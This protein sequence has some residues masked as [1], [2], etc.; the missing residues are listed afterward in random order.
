MDW[1]HGSLELFSGNRIGLYNI[2]DCYE[3]ITGSGLEVICV[4]D[5]R[6][7]WF[8]IFIAFWMVNSNAF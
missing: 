6:F 1:T 8:G 3:V 2:L 5:W 7:V 4:P